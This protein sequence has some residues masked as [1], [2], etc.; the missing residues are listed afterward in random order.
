MIKV[1]KSGDEIH[2][3]AHARSFLHRQ[4]RNIV[5]SLKL[6]GEGKWDPDDIERI[7]LAK[8]RAKQ[9]LQHRPTACISWRS[10]INDTYLINPNAL[11]SA[12]LNRKSNATTPTAANR[13][14]S[15]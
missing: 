15:S 14:I 11:I 1:S 10:F 13:E 12:M 5:G 7:L 2:I 3:I 8:N 9:A 6:V 4:I